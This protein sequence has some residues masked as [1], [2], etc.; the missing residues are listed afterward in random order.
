MNK[1]LYLLR[2]IIVGVL[3]LTSIPLVITYF[4]EIER[5]HRFR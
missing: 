1:I 4:T 2:M 3:V 5:Q